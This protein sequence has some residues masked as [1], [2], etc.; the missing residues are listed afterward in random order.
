MSCLDNSSLELETCRRD[1]VRRNGHTATVLLHKLDIISTIGFVGL[2]E[3]WCVVSGEIRP[4]LHFLDDLFC[5]VVT[6]D[7]GLWPTTLNCCSQDTAL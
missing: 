5:W 1:T 4:F 3:P 7:D 2:D 6:Q